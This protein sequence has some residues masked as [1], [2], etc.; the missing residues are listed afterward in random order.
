MP[1]I[2][3]LKGR[4]FGTEDKKNIKKN[5]QSLYKRTIIDYG[6]HKL[7]A[8]IGP[9]IVGTIAGGINGAPGTPAGIDHDGPD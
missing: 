6:M 2:P 1:F 9:D 4:V 5:R 7:A 8:G 3:P